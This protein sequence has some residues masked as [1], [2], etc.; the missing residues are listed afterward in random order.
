MQQI[1]TKQKLIDRHGGTWLES[2]HLKRLRG[3]SRKTT[4]SRSV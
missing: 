3:K 4:Y 1:K 2:Q